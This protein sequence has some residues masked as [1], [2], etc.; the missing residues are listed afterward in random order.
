MCDCKLIQHPLDRFS[1]T[2]NMTD[3]DLAGTNAADQLLTMIGDLRFLKNDFRGMC[4][5]FFLLVD[6]SW[7]PRLCFS[8]NVNP[9]KL[10]EYLWQLEGRKGEECQNTF[11]D[12]QMLLPFS[13]EAEESARDLPTQLGMQL[14][15]SSIQ[16]S[17]VNKHSL[18][19]AHVSD[20][21]R[22]ALPRSVVDSPIPHSV[23]H[24]S[25]LKRSK[26]KGSFKAHDKSGLA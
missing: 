24:E 1:F 11:D 5:G 23:R 19:V 12:P 9:E 6:Q 18:S 7:F 17:I 20:I 2:G 22:I 10:R 3:L 8:A 4:A 15:I 25:L 26:R 14:D 16:D 21:Q 13:T